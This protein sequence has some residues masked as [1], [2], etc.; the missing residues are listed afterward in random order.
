MNSPNYDIYIVD[1]MFT[2]RSVTPR[3]LTYAAIPKAVLKMIVNAP[4]VYCVCDKY[5]N[6]SIKDVERDAGGMSF[7]DVQ[8]TGPNQKCPRDYEDALCSSAFKTSLN[9]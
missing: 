9:F 2:V 5:N 1:A 8:I 7:V 4:I 6:P 3:P